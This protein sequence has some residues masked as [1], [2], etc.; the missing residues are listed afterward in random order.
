MRLSIFREILHR[1]QFEGAE[2]IDDNSFLC[3]PMLVPVIIQAIVLDEERQM[4]QF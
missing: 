4:L 2:F 3:P 1:Q